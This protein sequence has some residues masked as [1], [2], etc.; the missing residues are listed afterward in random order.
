[1]EIYYVNAYGEKVILNSWPCML[2]NQEELVEYE[3]QSE[4][5]EMREHREKILK[6]YMNLTKRKMELSIFANTKEELPGTINRMHRI[7]EKDVIENTPGKLFVGEAYL[8]CF[9]FSGKADEYEEEFY[10]ADYEVGIIPAKPFW[11]KEEKTTFEKYGEEGENDFL[12]FPYEFSYDYMGAQK[13]ISELN[14][15]HYAESDFKMIIY[16]PVKNP[17]ILIDGYSYQIHTTVEE[18]EYLEID[19]AEGTVVRTKQDGS[20]IDEFDNRDFENS[21]FR[22]IPSGRLSINWSGDFGWDIIV[23]K[24]R[25]APEWR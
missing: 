25:S 17:Q 21:V 9:C 5:K 6:F 22:K 20:R 7:F 8:Q 2:Q 1:M 3:W 18:N 24:E 11:I 12:E 14:I 10:A 13:G 23:F 15:E 4:I 16:G 19:S